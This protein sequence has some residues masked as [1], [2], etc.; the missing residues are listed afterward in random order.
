MIIIIVVIIINYCD[1][2]YYY[3]RILS[4]ITIKKHWTFG[5]DW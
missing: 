5:S 4:K 2:Y 3:V 1:Y